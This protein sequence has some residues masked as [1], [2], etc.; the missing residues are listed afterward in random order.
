VTPRRRGLPIA[1]AFGD[2][3][4]GTAR[5]QANPTAIRRMCGV[6]DRGVIFWSGEFKRVGRRLNVE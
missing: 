3:P 4:T 5:S 1:E 6:L 2:A